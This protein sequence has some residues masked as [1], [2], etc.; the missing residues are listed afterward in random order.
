MSQIVNKPFDWTKKIYKAVFRGTPN[1]LTTEDVNREFDNIRTASYLT[2]RAVGVISNI[3]PSFALNAVGNYLSNIYFTQNAYAIVG[4]VKFQLP[5]TSQ[6]MPMTVLDPNKEYHLNLYARKSL[7]D[8]DGNADKTISGAKFEDGSTKKAA[9]HYIYHNEALVFEEKLPFIGDVRPVGTK[10]GD[11][12]FITPLY[13]VRAVEN[14]DYMGAGLGTYQ[15]L[16][17]NLCVPMESTLDSKSSSFDLPT[18]LVRAVDLST[19]NGLYRP[20]IGERLSDVISKIYSRF[21]LLEKRVY[22]GTKSDEILTETNIADVGLDW[23]FGSSGNSAS[24]KVSWS[25]S[26]GMCTLSGYFEVSDTDNKDRIIPTIQID[27]ENLPAPLFAIHINPYI[28]RFTDVGGVV[29]PIRISAE[30]TAS[31]VLGKKA[32]INFKG[33]IEKG[34]GKR[35]YFSCSYIIKTNWKQDLGDTSPNNTF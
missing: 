10:G 14:L 31:P 2:Q 21:Y 35:Q 32:R 34:V 33:S 11:Y 17:K 15:H 3:S 7:V 6:F 30:L 12:E 8:F 23:A 25:V 26:G 13:S 27:F 1:L 24:A 18:A 9:D 19:P 28:G 29:T 20:R 16:I 22:Q 5:I 4:G